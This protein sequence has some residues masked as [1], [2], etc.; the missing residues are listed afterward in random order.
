MAAED[1]MSWHF[2]RYTNN[3]AIGIGFEKTFVGY[4]ALR[5]GIGFWCLSFTWPVR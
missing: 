4:Y 1:W 3:F 5:V 2:Y